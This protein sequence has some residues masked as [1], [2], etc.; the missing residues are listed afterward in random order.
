VLSGEVVV[1]AVSGELV[2]V[3]VVAVVVLDV[4]DV[5]VGLVGQIV[6]LLRMLPMP[7]AVVIVAAPDGFDRSRYMLTVVLQPLSKVGTETVCVVTVEA[8]LSE[9]DSAV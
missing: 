3:S 5:P 2:V 8:K 4:V 9:P 6:P 1:L 7:V